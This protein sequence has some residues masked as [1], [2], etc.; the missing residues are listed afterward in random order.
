MLAVMNRRFSALLALSLGILAPGCGGST[1][2]ATQAV[3]APPPSEVYT[4]YVSAIGN[5]SAAREVYPFLSAA[6]QRRV[7][8]DLETLKARVPGG[9]LKI[10]D[11]RIQGGRA[12]VIVSATIQDKA[13]REQLSTG[14]VVLVRE[15]G[16]WKVDQ[17]SWAAK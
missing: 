10:I 8:A 4:A 12:T 17:E 13:G 9:T 14:T 7:G 5:A 15:G 2:S 1:P 16:G 6:G 3:A 11:E